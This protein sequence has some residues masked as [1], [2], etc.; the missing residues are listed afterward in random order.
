MN[1]YDFDKT[2]FYPD[3]SQKFIFFCFKRYPFAVLPAL[4]RAIPSAVGFFLLK[5]NVEDLKARLFS[6]LPAV[7]NL[8]ET[9]E[10]FWNVHS[11]N[12]CRWYPA[13]RRDNDVVISGS[14]RFL[15]EPLEKKY[16][17]TLICTEMNEATGEIIGRN[18]SGA[19]KK[20]RFAEAFPGER[21]ECF[22]SDSRSDAPLAGLADKAFL[23]KKSKIIPWK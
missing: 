5:G 15:L 1:V 9:V 23:I 19:E 12:F 21:I 17:F 13:Q 4:I 3:S 8:T 11:E 6:F 2:L 22:Y 14:P 16:G 10:E 7:K 18:C 20:R